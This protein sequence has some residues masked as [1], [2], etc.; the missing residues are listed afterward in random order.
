MTTYA[1]GDI[2]GCYDDLMHLLESIH[3]EPANDT[4][5]FVGDLVNR[6][7]KSLE[8]L[9]FVKG[10]GD[11]AITV[12]GNHDLHL[13]ALD[14]G[15]RTPRKKDTLHEIFDAPD[16]DELL[17]WLRHRPLIHYDQERNQVLVH[18]GLPPQWKAKKAVQ[19]AAEVEEILRSDRHREL[20]HN[21]YGDEP[22]LWDRELTGWAR[23]R[24]IINA[25]T[26]MRYCSP[27]GRL[28]LNEKYAPG[29]QPKDLIPW[30]E[31]PE[32]CSR[33]KE[34]IFGHWSTLGLVRR[35]GVIALD[36]GCVWGGQLTAV[37]LD[38]RQRSIYSCDCAGALKPDTKE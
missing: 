14:A 2:Q 19:Y 15:G 5:W 28:N 1:I 9:R 18:A 26:R 21:M 20:F 3:F 32:R 23:I 25:L 12:L 29:T 11:G 6:G 35:K 8:T 24:F 30:F 4:L 38:D 17:H 31:A 33:K 13:L 22:T 7:P 36:T 37:D 16:C 34:I 27:D 10:L